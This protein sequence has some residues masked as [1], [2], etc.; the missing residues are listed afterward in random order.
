MIAT[1]FSEFPGSQEETQSETW[2]VIPF[3]PHPEQGPSSSFR[4][5]LHL[6]V[7]AK[8]WVL[9]HNSFPCASFTDPDV[10]S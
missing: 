2:N 9:R 10:K 7:C 8:N 4:D 3:L 1:T 6:F 5:L